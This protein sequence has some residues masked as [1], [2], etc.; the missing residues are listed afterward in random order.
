MALLS[1]GK[2]CIWYL[3]FVL[4]PSYTNTESCQL[5]ILGHI[6]QSTPCHW[7]M[8]LRWKKKKFIMEFA[9]LTGRIR[10]GAFGMVEQDR[11]MYGVEL[12]MFL[13]KKLLESAWVL[14]EELSMG[15]KWLC[16]PHFLWWPGFC[17]TCYIESQ[18]G[19]NAVQHWDSRARSEPSKTD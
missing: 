18:R 4:Q 12:Y 8:C 16:T 2:Q 6:I 14:V 7:N 19:Q 1:V 10:T 13:R 9:S 17:E 5:L 11:A 3:A 15:T